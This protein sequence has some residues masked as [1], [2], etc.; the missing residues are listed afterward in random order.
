LQAGFGARIFGLDGFSM[1]E[2]GRE[3]RSNF[4]KKVVDTKSTV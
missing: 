3:K 4:D 2:L 1:A